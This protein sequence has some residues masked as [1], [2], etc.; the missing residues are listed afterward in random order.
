MWAM[1]PFQAVDLGH[2][3]QTQLYAD[4][5]CFLCPVVGLANSAFV[6]LSQH[7]SASR[8]C[9]HHTSSLWLSNDLASRIKDQT[10]SSLLIKYFLLRLLTL[11]NHIF[12]EDYVLYL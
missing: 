4:F 7:P 5:S 12:N 8:T 1:L 6:P 2:V 9:P 10:Y 11:S 3:A